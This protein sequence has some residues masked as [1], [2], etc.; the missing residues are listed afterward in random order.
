MDTIR[1]F[2][3]AF[4]EGVPYVKHWLWC[5]RDRKK[6][7]QAFRS[8]GIK[9]LAHRT[10]RRGR[11]T[12]LQAQTQFSGCVVFSSHF[13]NQVSYWDATGSF[14]L[15]KEKEKHSRAVSNTQNA[16]WGEVLEFIWPTLTKWLICDRLCV[17][18][19]GYRDKQDMVLASGAWSLAE[20]TTKETDNYSSS[21][22]ILQSGHHRMLRRHRWGCQTQGLILIKP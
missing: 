21:W 5:S 4:L 19:W 14:F 17:K 15:S 1:L 16:V 3:H 9:E 20:E 11:L 12:S 2:Q 7:G 10:L 22:Y 18:D 8:H 6:L 13:D